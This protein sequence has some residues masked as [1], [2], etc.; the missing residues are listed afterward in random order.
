[1][2]LHRPQLLFGELFV[3]HISIETLKIV[4]CEIPTPMV[5]EGFTIRVYVFL[6]VC[7]RQCFFSFSV[8]WL[9]A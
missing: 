1:M 9:K 2:A 6:S 7:A 3:V 5:P 8:L 4:L